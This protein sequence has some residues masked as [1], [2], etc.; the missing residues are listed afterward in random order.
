MIERDKWIWHGMAG[1]YI[2]SDRCLFH[3][4]TIIGKYVVTTVGDLHDIYPGGVAEVA[5]DSGFEHLPC[6]A[7]EIGYKIFYET[8][9]FELAEAKKFDGR[10]QKKGKRKSWAELDFSGYQ[11][12]DEAHRGHMLMCEKW[13]AEQ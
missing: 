2:L 13:A 8:M 4:Q 1:H 5:K 3:L 11:T 12:E 10:R 9:V 6:G 7:R